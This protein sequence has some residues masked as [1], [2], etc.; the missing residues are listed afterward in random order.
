MDL[1]PSNV[2]K[3]AEKN[4]QDIL[5]SRDLYVAK[6]KHEIRLLRCVRN[7]SDFIAAKK[8]VENSECFWS[9][10]RQWS[11]DNID[12]VNSHANSFIID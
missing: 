9:G 8:G 11:L 1:T 3:E 10:F 5:D 2:T 12:T 4:I 7:L 6:T